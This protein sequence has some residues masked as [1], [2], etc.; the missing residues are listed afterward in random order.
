MDK[1][2]LPH[3]ILLGEVA[4]VLSEG[5]EVVISPTGNSMLPFIRDGRDRV[6]L[7]KQDDLAVGDIVLMYTG[8]RYILHRVIEIDG[9]QVTLMGD[10]NLK[11][12]EHGTRA[13]V[14]GT[15]TE[16]LRPG[17][18]S[19]R[20]GTGRFWRVLKPVRRYILAIYRRLI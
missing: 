2:V 19:V 13:E 15:V 12:V 14:I 16:I 17:G 4:A 5:R 3:D 11:S 7:R 1:R 20:P 8:G 18:R 9:E 6:V 10:G